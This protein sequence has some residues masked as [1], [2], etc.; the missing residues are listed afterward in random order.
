MGRPPPN[1]VR[2][3]ELTSPENR[4][5]MGAGVHDGDH[6]GLLSSRSA[7]TD[8]GFHS[9]QEI[10]VVSA[11]REPLVVLLLRGVVVVELRELLLIA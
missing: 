7:Q 10:C 3:D 5:A 9:A 2:R 6:T 11:G 1:A 8:T 4:G